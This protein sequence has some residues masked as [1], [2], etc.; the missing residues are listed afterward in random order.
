MLKIPF[1]IIF[2][3]FVLLSECCNY[4]VIK[5]FDNKFTV[6]WLQPLVFSGVGGWGGGTRGVKHS[7]I[8]GEQSMS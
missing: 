8:A 4:T 6:N 7:L 5:V 1:Y 3:Y 2:Q